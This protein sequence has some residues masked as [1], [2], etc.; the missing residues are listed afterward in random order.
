MTAVAHFKAEQLVAQETKIQYLNW[1][2]NFC[3]YSSAL[4]IALFIFTSEASAAES[5]T[6]EFADARQVFE[7]YKKLDLAGDAKLISLYSPAATIEAGVERERGDIRWQ[8]LDRDGLAREM[9]ASFKDEH[10]NS[11]KSEESYGKPKFKRMVFE[12]KPAIEVVF[13]GTSGQAGIKVTWILQADQ[14]QWLIVSEKS[15]TYSKVK[16]VAQ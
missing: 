12:G 9:V 16:A 10:L 7:L 5:K 1:W 8:K 15:V 2:K 11:L 3:R 13:H 4:L 6:E 14:G